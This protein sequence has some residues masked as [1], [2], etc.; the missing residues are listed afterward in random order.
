[1]LVAF[2]NISRPRA[3][4]DPTESVARNCRAI[5][6]FPEQMTLVFLFVCS[7]PN[8]CERNPELH[9]QLRHLRDM[10]EQITREARARCTP[11]ELV[12]QAHAKLNIAND[13]FAA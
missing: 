10:A 13:R 7:P 3:I 12:G 8:I 5:G 9:E 11:A 6:R 1:V 2:A 4:A